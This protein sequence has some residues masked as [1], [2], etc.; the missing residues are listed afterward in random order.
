MPLI[1][2]ILIALGLSMDCF[3]VSV[4][5]GVSIK[6][7]NFYKALKPALFFATFQI[8]MPVIGWLVGNAFSKAFQQFDHFVA[9]FILAFIGI[10]MIYESFQ[11]EEKGKKFQMDKLRILIGLSIATS[12]DALIVGF[13]LGFLKFPVFA[14]LGMVWLIT[15]LMTMTG[16]FIAKQ[17]SPVFGKRAEVIGGIILFLIGLKI[18]LEHLG[19]V[20][21]F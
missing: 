13:G 10:K 11:D 3:A 6:N 20:K 8:L 14:F 19:V 4:S 7:L 5:G 1:E 18:L 17:V 15:F 12:I 2:I 21:L 9:F 16:L